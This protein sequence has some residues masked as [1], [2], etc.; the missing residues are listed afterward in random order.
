MSGGSIFNQLILIVFLT[1]INAFF[2]AAEMAIVSTNKKKIKYRA[3]KGDK[4]AIR[5]LKTLSEPSRFLSTIQVG[6]TFA[7]F[8]SSASAAVGI[9]KDLG[10]FLDK[11]GVPFGQDIAFIG[12]TLILSYIILVFGELVPKRIALQD[13]EKF[14]VFAIKPIN[15]FS[16]FMSPFVS[17]LSFSTNTLVRLL[18]FSSSNVEEKVTLEEIRSLVEV[19][20]EQGVINPVEKEMIESVI[21]F[22]DKIAKEIMTARTEMFMIDVDELTEEKLEKMLNLKYSRIPVYRDSIDNIIGMLYLKDYLLEAYN[23][24]F[25]D[26]EIE[27]ILRKPY[28]VP[29]NKNINN[30]FSELQ[31]TKNHFAILIDEYGGVSGIVT[32]EDL[33][34]EIMG[35]IDDE[36]DY[37]K[38]DIEQVDE[39]TYYLRGRTSIKDINNRLD[40]NLDENLEYYDTLGGFILNLLGYIPEPGENNVIKYKNMEFTIEEV[41]KR[42]IRKV[43]IIISSENSS[44]I[45]IK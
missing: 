2:A 7:G 23:F 16:K 36:Y 21:T 31:R 37:E 17:F 30:L 12:V 39:N 34:E 6:I 24:G 40:L 15:I 10:S 13:S 43:K 22:D 14:A 42:K 9:S 18:G 27:N 44:N 19:G 33:I 20:Q 28:F 41:R 45:D 4:N 11:V 8:F 29:E 25:D 32:M 1:L 5:L 38:P 35:D 26:I 3:E